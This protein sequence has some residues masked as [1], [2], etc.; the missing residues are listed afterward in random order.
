MSLESRSKPMAE[1]SC[2]TVLLSSGTKDEGISTDHSANMPGFISYL[3]NMCNV[4]RIG[5]P[6]WQS[7]RRL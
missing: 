2:Q 6:S 4:S 3:S 7:S 1:W 5:F